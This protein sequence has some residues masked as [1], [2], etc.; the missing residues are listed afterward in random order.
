MFFD[1]VNFW[2]SSLQI[3]E[4]PKAYVHDFVVS[5]GRMLSGRGNLFVYL[6]NMIFH[7]V[8]STLMLQILVSNIFP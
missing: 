5:P 7:V 1:V 3:L 6:N 2:T 8:N 4:D